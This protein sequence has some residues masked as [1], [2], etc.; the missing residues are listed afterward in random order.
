[1]M[2]LATGR[3]AT[4][5]VDPRYLV[6]GLITYPAG[7]FVAPHRDGPEHGWFWRIEANV[8]CFRDWSH[9]GTTPDQAYIAALHFLVHQA[10]LV[11]QIEGVVCQDAPYVSS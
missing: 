8:G 4:P 7:I 10:E 11:K 3:T 1:M 9:G 2:D 5:T 6:P